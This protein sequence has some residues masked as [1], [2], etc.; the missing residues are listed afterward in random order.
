MERGL[1]SI[2]RRV[3]SFSMKREQRR[4]DLGLHPEEI[5]GCE[6]DDEKAVVELVIF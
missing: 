5:D 1:A 2:Q 3:D 6:Y 4:T